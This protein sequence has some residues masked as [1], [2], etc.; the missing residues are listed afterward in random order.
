[1][2]IPKFGDG[3][4]TEPDD[5]DRLMETLMPE[6][7]RGCR[8]AEFMIGLL[9]AFESSTGGPWA[10]FDDIEENCSGRET[11]SPA[12]HLDIKRIGLPDGRSGLFFPF[13]DEELVCPYSTYL[14]NISG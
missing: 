9:L 8:V 12:G 14:N 2:N 6:R 1:M 4:P 11:T 7:C 13:S 5:I 3:L 10:V